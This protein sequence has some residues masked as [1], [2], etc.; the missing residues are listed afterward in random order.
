MA[1]TSLPPLAAVRV[2]EE[3]ARRENF[4]Q[5]AEQLGMTQA[6]VSYQIKILEERVGAPLF[7]RQARGVALSDV[8]K[9]F[10]DK[11]TEALN[12]LGEAFTEAKGLSQET[13]SV[14]VIPTFGTNFLAQHLGAFQMNNPNIA[15]RLEVSEGLTNFATDP[16]DVGIRG[17]DG[18][19]PGLR[20]YLLMR[21]NFTPMLSKELADSI[22][23][24][25]EPRDLL[26]LPILS[27]SDPWWLQ[28]CQAAGLEIPDLAGRPNQ[29]LGPQ[30]LEANAALAGQGVAMLTPE[31]FINEL[32]SGRLVQPFELTCDDGTAYWLVIPENHRHSQKIRKFHAWLEEVTKEFRPLTRHL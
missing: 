24:V 26:K 12:I 9:K 14:S 29:R 21:T 6:A 1:R 11:A 23:G 2:F 18:N 8:G 3:A 5:A 31:F 7:V 20:S 19:W 15:V 16:I 13:L 22:G 25:V 17:G 10:A 30:I 32:S 27:P 4:T 28:W